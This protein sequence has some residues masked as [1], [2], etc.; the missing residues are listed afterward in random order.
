M[1]IL[2]NHFPDNAGGAVVTTKAFFGYSASESAF[3]PNWIIFGI[4]TVWIVYL[5]SDY[6][7]TLQLLETW[8]IY[9]K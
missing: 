4:L 3:S 8:F 5:D 6:Y 2:S 1:P 9:L 7:Y